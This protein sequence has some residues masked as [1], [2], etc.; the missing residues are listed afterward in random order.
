M[1]WLEF[2]CKFLGNGLLN[3]FLLNV[4]IIKKILRHVHISDT[5]AKHLCIWLLTDVVD[6][7]LLASR[8]IISA[9][10]IC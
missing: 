5:L 2:T 7:I 3:R 4:I 10:F 1:L 9:L 6:M 8:F